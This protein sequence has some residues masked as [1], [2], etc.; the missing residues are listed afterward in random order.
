MNK[1]EPIVKRSLP[2]EL[3]DEEKQSRGK[4]LADLEYAKVEIERSKK[5]AMERFKDELTVTELAIEKLVVVIRSGI[6]D[7]EVE[8]SWKT[9]WKTM[10]KSLTRLDTNE[11][12]QTMTVPESDRQEELPLSDVPLCEHCDDPAV[13]RDSEDA[14]FC[15]A[16]VKLGVGEVTFIVKKE[17]PAEAEAR[18][19]AAAADPEKEDMSHANRKRR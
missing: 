18:V 8:C 9:D 1:V 12:V 15:G 7:R 17:T 19:M 14:Y 13:A 11:V 4:Y 6:E 16:H 3:T 2:C 10:L 5:I